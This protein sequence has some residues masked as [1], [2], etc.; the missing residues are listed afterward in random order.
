MPRY[1]IRTGY[2]PNIMRALNRCR[3]RCRF[4]PR[5]INSVVNNVDKSWRV[6]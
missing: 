4:S 6:C 2:H 5:W 3:C 1:E